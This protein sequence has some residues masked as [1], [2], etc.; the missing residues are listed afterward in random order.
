MNG[1]KRGVWLYEDEDFTY[2]M[3]SIT[4]DNYVEYTQPM[5]ET[6][7]TYVEVPMRLTIRNGANKTVPALS[8][9]FKFNI[10]SNGQ[11]NKCAA[12]TV[13][14]VSETLAVQSF[15]FSANATE[16]GQVYNFSVPDTLVTMAHNLAEAECRPKYRIK[17][18][19]RL[20]NTYMYWKDLTEEFVTQFP[21]HRFESDIH[22]DESNAMLNC[23]F[24][25]W[26][27]EKTKDYFTNDGELA[28][29][30]RVVAFLPGSEQMSASM[31][32]E[33]LIHIDF[34]LV[35]VEQEKVNACNELQLFDT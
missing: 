30:F 1:P 14:K 9:Q 8:Q 25:F 26:D 15:A 11:A 17:V 34:K 35:V 4:Q 29:D 3:A 5:F 20:T 16:F 21:D 7:A 27:V 10:T 28:I 24:S 13:E 32:D 23:S 12:S 31:S 19:N 22:F 2:I 18:L 6:N 33:Q